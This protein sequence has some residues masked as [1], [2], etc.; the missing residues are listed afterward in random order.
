MKQKMIIA[1]I[2]PNGPC[3]VVAGTYQDG[4]YIELTE[5][6]MATLKP[7]S[8]VCFDVAY[9]TKD[10]EDPETFFEAEFI[11]WREEP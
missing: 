3:E 10:R 7:G 5:S 2:I 6:D 4:K 1:V 9:L 11:E 8:I